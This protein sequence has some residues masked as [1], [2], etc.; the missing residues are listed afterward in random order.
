MGLI[1]DGRNP[2]PVEVGSYSVEVGSSSHYIQ[3]FIG[4]DAGCLP[5]HGF[6]KSPLFFDC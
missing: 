5:S 2:A 6:G 3:G 1:I 4:G